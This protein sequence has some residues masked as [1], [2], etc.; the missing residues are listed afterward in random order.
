MTVFFFSLA[1]EL[2]EIRR[3]RQAFNVKVIFVE[4]ILHNRTIL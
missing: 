2:T 3:M 1:V 4:K